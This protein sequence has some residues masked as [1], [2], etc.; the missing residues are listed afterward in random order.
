MT[1]SSRTEHGPA[2]R[3]ARISCPAAARRMVAASAIDLETDDGGWV[4]ARA[5]RSN[6]RTVHA[7]GPYIER[8]MDMRL[9]WRFLDEGEYPHRAEV[10]V[11]EAHV[12]T[13]SQAALVLEVAAVEPDRAARRHARRPVSGSATLTA[14]EC[15]CLAGT[16]R[17]VAALHDISASGIGLVVTDDRVR[18]GDRFLFRARLPEGPVD[19]HVR[20]ARVSR[21]PGRGRLFVGAAILD[22]VPGAISPATRSGRP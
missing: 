10:R 14:V 16:E 18:S 4:E 9:W 12:G 3:P 1:A 7:N 22:P 5:I 6:G 17:I 11:V 15:E 20:V 2:T 8:W 19:T 21:R 13:T